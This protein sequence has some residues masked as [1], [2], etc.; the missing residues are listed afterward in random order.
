MHWNNKN[1]ISKA[2]NNTT[3]FQNWR[4][5][6]NKR[7]A[8][9]AAV[10]VMIEGGA[11]SRDGGEGLELAVRDILEERNAAAV[12]EL[13]VGLGVAGECGA[14]ES[15]DGGDGG[16]WAVNGALENSGE[17]RNLDGVIGEHLDLVV[18]RGS[19]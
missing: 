18:V 5:S 16:V 6:D 9:A 1:P 11:V 17:M 4:R 13:L 19:R 12:V 7:G 15:D 8:A 14:L 2:L 10:A 3:S